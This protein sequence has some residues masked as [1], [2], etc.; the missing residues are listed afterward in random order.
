MKCQH[1]HN[2]V[3]MAMDS[4]CPQCNKRLIPLKKR[5]ER[6]FVGK[7]MALKKLLVAMMMA[8]EERDIYSGQ[9]RGK[10]LVLADPKANCNG[11]WSQ[12]VFDQ[13]C[14]FGD[15]CLRVAYYDAE[16][17]VVFLLHPFVKKQ[18]W[19]LLAQG[20]SFEPQDNGNKQE[21]GQE[22]KNTAQK[23]AEEVLRR[24]GFEPELMDIPVAK[25]IA[26]R[27]GQSRT[28]H[29]P[30]FLDES[31][32]ELGKSMIQY[33]QWVPVIARRLPDGSPLGEFEIIC[34]ER[35]L[36]AARLVG[37]PIL[38]AI[39][40]PVELT[41]EIGS[42]GILIENANRKN[43]KYMELALYFRAMM[44]RYGWSQTKVAEVAGVKNV[45]VSRLLPLCALCEEAQQLV[46]RYAGDITQA[47]ALKVAE[48]KSARV[49]VRVLKEF[50]MR[51]T[52]SKN[53]AKRRGSKTGQGRQ[54]RPIK[55]V[56]D[57]RELAPKAKTVTRKRPTKG[58]KGKTG[59]T[60]E[61]RMTGDA[62]QSMA[63]AVSV[64]VKAYDRLSKDH[65]LGVEALAALGLE[66]LRL[67]FNQLEVLKSQISRVQDMIE[68]IN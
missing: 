25:T 9:K 64:A 51:R 43:P 41:D 17:N 68:E 55:D 52:L 56:K 63:N 16:R 5:W 21:G 31:L 12:K 36:R 45:T 47:H 18:P 34:G 46:I 22:E 27:A 67:L 14:G 33:S 23:K 65:K 44:D 24:S 35:R 4:P 66:K 6:L 26:W 54:G 59:T 50:V 15:D 11:T 8:A 57:I 20:W 13:L 53:D 29:S 30:D 39:V 32:R 49:Q 3:L 7:D 19:Q 38:R 40:F 42:V 28:E 58:G 60:A 61:V 1:G 62:A 10:F 37:K 48:Y 2:V